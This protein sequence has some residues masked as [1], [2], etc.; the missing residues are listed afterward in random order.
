MSIGVA[1]HHALLLGLTPQPE[2]EA[3]VL[4]QREL[5]LVAAL[6]LRH[7]QDLVG[8]IVAQ[9][10]CQDVHDRCELVGC[11]GERV[12]HGLDVHQGVGATTL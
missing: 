10:L 2:G 4:V 5:A 9:L 12:E 6:Q 8:Q 11:G 1:P 3:V 7:Q